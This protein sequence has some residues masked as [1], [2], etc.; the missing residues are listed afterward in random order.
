MNE[1]FQAHPI[2]QHYA[3]AAYPLV[4]M[5][6]AS[7]TTDQWLLLVRRHGRRFAP[8]PGLIAIR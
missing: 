5:H 8:R 3:I 7:I 6:D 1:Q 4:F 2:D